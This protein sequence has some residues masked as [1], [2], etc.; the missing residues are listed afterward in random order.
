MNEVERDFSFVRS[1]V[2]VLKDMENELL[3]AWLPLFEKF[4]CRTTEHLNNY[5]A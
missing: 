3:V 2:L 4:R 1:A 5:G